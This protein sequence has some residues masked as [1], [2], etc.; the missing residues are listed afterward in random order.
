MTT[1]NTKLRE[2]WAK[3]PG[4]ELNY[5]TVEFN[6]PDINTVYLVEDLFN[7]KDFD[8]D[9]VTQTFRATSMSVPKVTDQAEDSSQAGTIV[10]GRIG[11][12]FRQELLKITPL[13]SLTSITCVL[14]QYQDSQVTP[15]YERSLFVGNN[16]ISFDDNNVNVR[17]AID[18]PAKLTKTSQIYDAATWVGLKGL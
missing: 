1:Y 6:H 9:G 4:G 8:V 12:L 14:R 7:D 17:L 16:G 15:V 2:Y 3:R 11:L 18:N 13:G 10:F 5:I